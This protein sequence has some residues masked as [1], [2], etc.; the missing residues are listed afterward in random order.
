MP[1]VKGKQGTKGAKQIKE[2][3]KSTYSFY[4]YIIIGANIPVL[5]FHVFMRYADIEWTHLGLL[6]FSTLIYILCMK[7]MNSMLNSQLDLNMEAGMS[8]HVKDIILVTAVCQVL[9]LA[10]LY[11]W[12]IWPQ[13]PGVGFVQTV[14][15]RPGS[16]DIRGATGS[17][18]ETAEENGTE[19]TSIK[20]F[21][22]F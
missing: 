12:L 4:S 6:T 5:I 3:N 10:S 11:A 21:I 2:E 17:D 13:V 16:V 14:G 8:E 7:T 20:T 22:I 9:S 1:V 18:G 19:T 15:E